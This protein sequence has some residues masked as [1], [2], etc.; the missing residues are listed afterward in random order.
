MSFEPRSNTKMRYNSL[1]GSA[2][3]SWPVVSGSGNHQPLFAPVNH[4]LSQGRRSVGA[5]THRRSQ[6]CCRRAVG[7][8]GG[9][10]GN[11]EGDLELQDRLVDQL[12]IGIAK[13][14]V[15][16]GMLEDLEE[17]KK[18]L[19]KIGDDLTDELDKQLALDKARMNLAGSSS[20]A[21]MLEEFRQLDEDV[22]RIRD[23][24]QILLQAD[25]RDLA[26]FER[27]NAEERSR[28]L[29]FKNLYSV[30]DE[31]EPQQGGSKQPDPE[32]EEQRRATME[33]IKQPARQ[34]LRS[35]ARL[36]LFTYLTIVL[37]WVIGEDI[38]LGDPDLRRDVLYGLLCAVLGFNAWNERTALVEE[39]EAV[40]AQ[41]QE[42]QQRAS[43]GE[44]TLQ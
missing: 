22:Q 27:R 32:A 5:R 34:E 8:N 13:A 10:G 40:K 20:L 30:K 36:A 35:P 44:D 16:E 7:G 17:R 3:Q 2:D 37:A 14:K 6:L 18:S 1:G 4:S 26:A 41:E 21:D 23:E 28:G 11:S 15:K 42:E 31:G 12:Q 29:F 25:R 9:P 24:L 38:S 39:R 43:Q 19:R 33:N